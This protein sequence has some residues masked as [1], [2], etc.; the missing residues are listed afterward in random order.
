[1]ITGV[2]DCDASLSIETNGKIM[3]HVYMGEGSCEPIIEGGVPLTDLI[4]DTLDSFLLPRTKKIPPYHEEEAQQLV[5]ELKSAV[6][7]AKRRIKEL[8]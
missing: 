8:S 6:K 3:M 7:Y 5:A 4:E 2:L 1:M